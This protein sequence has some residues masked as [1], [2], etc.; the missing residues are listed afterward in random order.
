MT[1]IPIDKPGATSPIKKDGK[2]RS[3]FGLKPKTKPENSKQTSPTQRASQI[4]RTPLV[5]SQTNNKPSPPPPII[6]RPRL[7]TLTKNYLRR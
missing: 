4:T 5:T 3:F 1:N 6:I 7:F 2:L